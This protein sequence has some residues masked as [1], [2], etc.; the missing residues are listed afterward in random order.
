VKAEHVRVPD[1]RLHLSAYRTRKLGSS[2]LTLAV[3]GPAAAL[4]AIAVGISGTAQASAQAQPD[5]VAG[6]THLPGTQSQTSAGSGARVRAVLDSSASP[7]VTP[8][9]HPR[10]HHPRK[11][12][13][14]RHHAR[15]HHPRR[16]HRRVT[17]H[18][19]AKSM[20]HRFGW[21]KRQFKFLNWL[22][23]RES[24]WNVHASNPYSGA[25]GIPQAVPGSKMASAGPNWQTSARTQIRWGLDYIKGR[26][27][28]PR[29]A[30]DHEI[31]YG[32]Y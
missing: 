26:Y 6:A 22:W 29:N 18:G 20:L 3:T 32:W 31:A 4:L 5:S 12:H 11:H 30:W 10:K 21:S 7:L 2:L 24:S 13:R 28:S 1:L 25:Y 19:I 17:P 15:R 14:R 23:D 8:A 9:H 27:G 16:H